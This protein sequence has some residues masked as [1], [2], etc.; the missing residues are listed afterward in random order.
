MIA[1]ESHI[2]IVSF[3]LPV[4]TTSATDYIS[5]VLKKMAFHKINQKEQEKDI[6]HCNKLYFIYLLCIYLY[7]YI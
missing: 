7:I 5:Y 4:I 1:N 2:H 6:I 3:S